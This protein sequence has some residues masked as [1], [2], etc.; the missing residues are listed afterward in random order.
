MAVRDRLH[1]AAS[2]VWT[3]IRRA[4]GTFVWLAI[5]LVTTIIAHDLSDAV[6]RHVLGDRSTNLHHL[7]EDPLRVLVTSAFWLAGGPWI[8]YLLL[9]NIFHVPAERWLGTVRWLAVCVVAHVGATYLSEGVLY[10]AI[11]HGDA[12]A[13][14]VN[15]LDVG[16][17]YALAGV[18]AVLT[19]R[20]VSP[21]RYLYAGGV[22][23]F[24]VIPVLTN[25]TFTDVGHLTAALIGFACWPLTR[26]RT[27]VWDPVA[28]LRSGYSRV[29]AATRI[30]AR[31]R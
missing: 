4:P 8:S 21:W 26:G 9:Y 29:V 10:W 18:A 22:V 27:G 5:L 3:Y 17:S 7:R 28:A 30:V 11:R 12:P 25:Q 6:L 19:Y 16:V 20:I 13:R 31:S 1:L 24:F 2:A 23:V 15:T 14:A